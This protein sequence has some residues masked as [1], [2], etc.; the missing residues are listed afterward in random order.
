MVIKSKG[1]QNVFFR[2]KI[3]ASIR[4]KLSGKIISRRRERRRRRM[5]KNRTK[6]K[7]SR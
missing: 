6:K 3:V 1:K 2:N 4:I 5:T 7:K